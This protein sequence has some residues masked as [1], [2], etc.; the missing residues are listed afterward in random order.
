MSATVQALKKLR[1]SETARPFPASRKKAVPFPFRPVLWTYGIQI[2][3]AHRQ[4][5][6]LTDKVPVAVFYHKID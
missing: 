1:L 4:R 3:S 6:S 5:K 2:M